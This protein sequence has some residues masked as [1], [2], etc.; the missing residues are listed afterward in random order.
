[1]DVVDL[2]YLGFHVTEVTVACFFSSDLITETIKK[3]SI[4]NVT[5]CLNFSASQG[6]EKTEISE[7][8][9]YGIRPANG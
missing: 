1:M 9:N 2:K 8:G 3:H 6:H 7:K 4:T 5:M